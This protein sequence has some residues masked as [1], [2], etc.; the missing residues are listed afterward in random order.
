MTV[1]SSSTY[2][3]NTIDRTEAG[4]RTVHELAPP[5]GCS[6]WWARPMAVVAAVK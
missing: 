5:P 2:T 3:T 6:Y 4:A 1:M